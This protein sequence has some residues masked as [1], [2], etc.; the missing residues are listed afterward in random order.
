MNSF[1]Y[2]L[3]EEVVPE[4][5]LQVEENKKRK[6]PTWKG[7]VPADEVPK[8]RTMCEEFSSL[9]EE[10]RQLALTARRRTIQETSSDYMT[11][12]R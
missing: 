1:I 9:V 3:E 11:G 7:Y 2:T 5:V 10:S 4:K 6:K 8:K 12:F